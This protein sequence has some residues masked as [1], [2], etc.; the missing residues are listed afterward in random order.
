MMTDEVKAFLAKLEDEAFRAAFESAATAEAKA[1]LLAEAGLSIAV[2]EA[3]E[4]L[5]GEWELSD[6]DVEGVAG[7]D[8]G[9]IRFPKP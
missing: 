6:E 7:G 3:E 4:V 5:K 2:E 8:A 1:R 9:V